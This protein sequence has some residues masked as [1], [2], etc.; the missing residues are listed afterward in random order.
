M[1]TSR[2]TLSLSPGG[3][4]TL[5]AEEFEA[6][7]ERGR[8]RGR[9]TVTFMGVGL[10]FLLL[11][12][13]CMGFG[14]FAWLGLVADA[15]LYLHHDDAGPITVLVDGEVVAE[16]DGPG[17]TLL[18]LVRGDRVVEVMGARRGRWEL[19]GVTG[20]DE[21]LIRTS[22]D[23]CFVVVDVSNALYGSED[24]DCD[25]L[26]SARIMCI[27][28]K[29]PRRDVGSP[30]FRSQDL[31]ERQSSSLATLTL[32]VPCGELDEVQAS[33]V[34]ADHLGCPDPR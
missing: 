7:I 1:T 30:T 10:A 27:Y 23:T 9:R 4:V 16:V 17:A 29:F 8:E 3:A 21:W 19:E 31:P 11:G 32:P 14:V 15:R 13:L 18:Y 25:D 28:R 34:L 20:L 12:S 26:D 6:A 22:P 33:T 24:G 5:Y 2:D